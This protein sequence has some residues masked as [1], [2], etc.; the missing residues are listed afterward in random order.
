MAVIVLVSSFSKISY[1]FSFYCGITKQI[2]MQNDVVLFFIKPHR[3]MKKNPNPNCVFER[4]SEH[5]RLQ[6][7]KSSSQRDKREID[8]DR[9]KP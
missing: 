1:R 7:T 3:F 2:D 4:P 6:A 9:D 8:R 5:T